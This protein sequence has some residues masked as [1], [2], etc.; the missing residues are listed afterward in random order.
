[1]RGGGSLQLQILL[2]VVLTV[3]GCGNEA[4]QFPASTLGPTPGPGPD[5]D[6][7]DRVYERNVVFMTAG[8]DS[9]MIVPWLFRSSAS[10]QG[11]ERVAEGGSRGQD[12]W[13]RSLLT[14][15]AHLRHVPPFAFTPAVRWTWWWART[16]S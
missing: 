8:A 3:V 13:R 14:D 1:M 12:S 7:E 9:A 16:T 6:S 15:G 4:P 11:I 5:R 2:G 10:E